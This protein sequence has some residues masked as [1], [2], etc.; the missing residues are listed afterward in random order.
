MKLTPYGLCA[1]VGAFIALSIIGKVSM[2]LIMIL[3]L[4]SVLQS[5]LCKTC[6]STYTLAAYLAT[7]PLLLLLFLDNCSEIKKI[8]IALLIAMAIGRIG[9]Y[10]AGCC[11]GKECHKH[12]PL[13]INYKKGSV[14]VDKYKKH[15]I[16]VYPSIYLEILSQFLI[17]YIVY[18]NDYGIVFAGILNMILLLF[19]F[20]WREVKRMGSFEDYIPVISLG[21]FS[22]IAYYKC[23]K[24][25]TSKITFNPKL[26]FAI[27]SIFVSF[28]L[29]ND[30]NYN[31]I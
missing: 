29:S 4:S 30:I 11:T 15:D 24:T 21:I 1:G 12:F 23:G 10:F 9:C 25:K 3:I 6:S 31:I 20:K 14:I 18:K 27:F 13:A 16:F 26:S 19:T 8:L 22:V 17:A 2:K 5:I 7:T 28:I